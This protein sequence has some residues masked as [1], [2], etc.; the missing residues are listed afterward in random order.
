MLHNDRRFQKGE[1]TCMK[2]KVSLLLAIAMLFSAI[3]IP[4]FAE[5]PVI[6][7]SASGFYYIEANG[8]QVKLSAQDKSLFIQADGLYFKD[9]NKNGSLDVYEDWRNDIDTRVADLVSQM[10]IDMKL[11]NL[12]ND[13]TGG[14]FSPIYPMEDEWLYSQEDHITLSDN[15]TYRPMWYEINKNHVTHYSYSSTGTPKEQQDVLNAIQGIGEGAPLGIPISF[16]T[17]RPYNT[18]GSMINMPY[19]AF[20]VAHDPEL[21]YNMVSQYSKEMAAMGYTT[22]FHSYGVEIGSWYGDEVNYISEMIVPETLAYE[23]NGLHAMTKHYIA[24]GGRNSFANARSDAQL[25]ENYM[26]PWKAAVQEGKTSTIMLNAGYGINNTPIYYDANTLGYL[27]NELGFEGVLCTDWPLNMDQYNSGYT[28]DGRLIGDMTLGEKYAWM[29]ECGIDQFGVFRIEH[30]LDTSNYYI[31]GSFDCIFWP[32]ALKAEIEAGRMDIKVV[33]DALARAMKNKFRLGLFED[34]FNDYAEREALFASDEYKA[35]AFELNSVD[36]VIR[37][38]TPQMNAWDEELME[39]SSVLLKNDNDLLPLPAGTKIHVISNSDEIAELDT[40]AI[41]EKTTVVDTYEEADVVVAHM[42]ALGDVWEYVI[43]DAEAAGK[44]IVLVLQAS[45]GRNGSLIEPAERE[46]MACGAIIME[47]YDSLPDHGTALKGFYH[48]TYPS[49]TADFLFGDRVP[50]GSL[51]YEIGRTAEDY[52]LSWGD[53]QLDIGMDDYMRL[54]L[55]AAIRN[56]PD[57]LVPNNLGDSLYSSNFGM[58]Y[59]AKPDF[60]VNTLI[61]P[62]ELVSYEEEYRGS[63]RTVTKALDAVQKAGESF[64]IMFIAQNNG[65]DGTFV[66]EV[67]DGDTLIASKFVSLDAGQFRVVTFDLTLEAGEH[68]I[69]VC[70]LTK[71]I[72]VE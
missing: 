36:D 7:E 10:D 18:F 11:G 67:Y 72:V 34:P 41:G 71:T 46:A 9:L 56:Q 50:A 5:E 2:K 47:T 62:K 14:A 27:R 3:G 1:H 57:L 60:D 6:K 54:Y 58:T 70:G 32:D 39:K 4:A 31:S 12:A 44:P 33:D 49:V 21:L 52:L 28:S 55:A 17:D 20:G 16:E 8:E 45:V 66:A 24:R 30:G 59:G 63:M 68:N 53:L 23:E 26:V 29:M 51:V 69:N 64:P 15:I 48:Y 35:E 25:W 38:R 42:T 40:A 37:A 13:F 19:Y 65:D 61:V 22:I 43:E